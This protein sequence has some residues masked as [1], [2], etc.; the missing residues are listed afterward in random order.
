MC[1]EQDLIYA[2]GRPSHWPIGQ[3]TNWSAPEELALNFP[4]RPVN[5][6]ASATH[7]Y[8]ADVEPWS[9]RVFVGPL[10]CDVYAP[11]SLFLLDINDDFTDAVVVWANREQFPP[12]CSSVNWCVAVQG[13]EVVVVGVNGHASGDDGVCVVIST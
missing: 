12:V 7:L 4:V 3:G 8:W 1:F 5:V 6:E 11:I 13:P 10:V 9:I 2:Y